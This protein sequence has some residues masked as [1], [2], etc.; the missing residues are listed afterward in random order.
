[1]L[2]KLLETQIR[3]RNTK[4]WTSTVFKNLEERNFVASIEE[5][6][7]INKSKFKRKLNE[8]TGGKSLNDLNN[9]KAGHS[10]F[11]AFNDENEELFQTKYYVTN[12]RG[13]ST[14]SQ[15]ENKND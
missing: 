14:N 12:Q 6:K 5:I 11:K 13:N 9:L 4:E 1:M 7:D 10:K 8:S 15:D 2:Y 3:S